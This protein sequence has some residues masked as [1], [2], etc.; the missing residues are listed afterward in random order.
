MS[1]HVAV[2]SR[3]PD[4]SNAFSMPGC[5]EPSLGGHVAVGSRSNNS[6]SFEGFFAGS[7]SSPS[8]G[9]GGLLSGMGSGSDCTSLDYTSRNTSVFL[10]DTGGAGGGG[11]S[12]SRSS[13]SVRRSADHHNSKREERHPFANLLF[14]IGIISSIFCLIVTVTVPVLD[15][16][17]VNFA[18]LIYAGTACSCV[19]S[20][21]STDDG[22]SILFSM[23]AL[24]CYI[25]ALSLG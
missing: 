11:A 21:E 19:S 9:G 5:S 16:L 4:S 23:G 1:S 18:F 25:A 15:P 13:S 7:G 3:N 6:S 20:Q 17:F 8:R 24:W 12:N 14:V 2:G 10:I 22:T